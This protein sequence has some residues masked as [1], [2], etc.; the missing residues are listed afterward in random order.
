M[1]CPLVRLEAG[2]RAKQLKSFY[3]NMQHNAIRLGTPTPS[4]FIQKAELILGT[5]SKHLIIVQIGAHTGWDE[6]G[7]WRPVHQGNDMLLVVT[8]TRTTTP[9]R[10]Y[11][12]RSLAYKTSGTREKD[13]RAFLLGNLKALHAGVVPDSSQ[14]PVNLTFHGIIADV[15][16]DFGRDSRSGKNLPT[17][18]LGK[19][20]EL[21]FKAKHSQASS[22]LEEIRTRSKELH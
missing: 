3:A 13:S 21:F 5:P 11:N 7:E 4:V 6:N 10:L 8:A 15:D 2:V 22:I 1:T 16:V 18:Y 20:V 12:G 9:N 14:S 19:S 17:V